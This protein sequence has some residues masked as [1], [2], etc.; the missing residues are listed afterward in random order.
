MRSSTAGYRLR[1]DTR[2]HEETLT[3]SSVTKGIEIDVPVEEV[4]AFVSDPQ[5]RAHAMA[6]A[7]DRS[8]VV[9]DDATSPGGGRHELEVD[10]AV[11]AAPPLPRRRD[12]DR[13]YRQPAHPREA[14]DPDQGRRRV[15]VR[16]I[17]QQHTADLLRPVLLADPALG[18]G[19]KS[20]S[21][22]RARATDARS[23]IVWPRSSSRWRPHP[24]VSGSS[25]PRPHRSG[26]DRARGEIAVA[27]AWT[28][29]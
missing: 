25:R 24:R 7:F 2:G 17:G 18:E 27:W 4:F 8:I 15:H 11:S 21:P 26:A 19:G 1:R 23:K 6:R 10:H 29:T 12:P 9:S 28:A 13:T 16:T 3:T 20:F 22:R 14:R 5:R